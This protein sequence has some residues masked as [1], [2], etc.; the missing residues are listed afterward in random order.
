MIRMHDT[1]ITLILYK[2]IK[3]E[4]EEQEECNMCCKLQAYGQL[5]VDQTAGLH[6]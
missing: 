3:S 6:T 4:E 5:P 2:N 1:Q